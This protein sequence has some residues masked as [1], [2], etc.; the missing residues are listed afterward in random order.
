MSGTQI[1]IV[2]IVLIVSIGRL[3]RSRYQASHGIIEDHKGRQQM[4]AR[5]EDEATKAEMQREL[6]TLRERVKVLE[7]IATDDRQGRNLAQEI[8]SLR[9]K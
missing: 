8:E 5:P 4:I 3:M 6:D 2:M 1:M 7:R 9:E